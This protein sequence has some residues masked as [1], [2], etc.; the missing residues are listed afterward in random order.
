LAEAKHDVTY[1]SVFLVNDGVHRVTTANIWAAQDMKCY[2][3]GIEKYNPQ[4]RIYGLNKD[5]KK[6]LSYNLCSYKCNKI[7]ADE[8]RRESA[9]FMCWV[10]GE[11]GGTKCG[12]CRITT[13]CSRKCQLADWPEH[14]KIC[15]LKS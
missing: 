8:L 3:C 1:T 10:C 7:V 5:E 11:P 9:V 13:Y 4:Y 15:N 6:I 2:V 14:K 12:K